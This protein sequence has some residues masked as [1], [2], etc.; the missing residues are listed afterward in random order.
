MRVLVTGASGFLGR[1]VCLEAQRVGHEAI[2]LDLYTH[3]HIPRI[4]ADI[5]K[6][7]SPDLF[8][9]AGLDAV[10]HMAAIAAPRTCDA[11]PGLAYNVNVNGTHQVIK[12]AIE[13]GAKK[14]VFISSAHVYGI[15]SRYFP[16]N[17]QHPLHPQETYTTTKILGEKLC[18]L[19]YEN[20][21]LNY[22]TL[23]LF[24]A[25]GPGQLPG[26]F[27]PDMALKAQNGGIS[28]TGGGTTK[29]FVYVDDVVKAVLLALETSFVGPLNIGTGVE[30]SLSSVAMRI[31]N[32][33]DA[34]CMADDGGTNI[35]RMQCDWSRAEKILGWSPSV[36]LDEGLRR[37]LQVSMGT[38]A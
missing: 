34:D 30:S 36:G 19:Y 25:Y 11:D 15:S 4:K 29:D 18:E 27:I 2:G 35:T 10:V 22:T 28:L 12:L 24:N 3:T 6:P 26:Y 9:T 13:S 8:G 38:V 20:Y 23:R 31:A 14:L 5:T 1:H 7:L 33:L 37:T 16:A 21:G 17:E 32:Q